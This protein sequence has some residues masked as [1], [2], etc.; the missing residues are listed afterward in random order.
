MAF[1][2]WK[3]GTKRESA[4][5]DSDGGKSFVR[6]IFYSC[7]PNDTDADLLE[8]VFYPQ[9]GAA[10]RDYP[11]YTCESISAP[12][13]QDALAGSP[14]G[15]KIYVLEATYKKSVSSITL[16]IAKSG[17]KPWELGVQ[18]VRFGTETVEIPWVYGYDDSGQY[19]QMLTTAGTPLTQTKTMYLKTIEYDISY[20]YNGKK[21]H[22][23]E[24]H[25]YN[26]N[27]VNICGVDIDSYC[28]KM[29][30]VES[31]IYT[32]YKS[33]GE[34]DYQYETCHYRI[35]V[36]P[37]SW[38]S[39]ILNVSTLA[40]WPKEKG[41]SSSG[42]LYLG[43]IY[44]YTPWKSKSASMNANTPPEFGSIDHVKQAQ[45][46]YWEIK[47]SKTEQIPW[48]EITEPMPLNSNGILDIDAI[49]DPIN[50]PYR[51]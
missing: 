25:S 19:K 7:D 4:Q 31:Q 49:K 29:M 40:L 26:K 42:N 34:I 48:E 5:T 46:E 41:A 10:H 18:N 17:K 2:I 28:G 44:R 20:K 30:P 32:E 47:G 6:E 15:K 33:N 16:G 43:A 11:S 1:S 3:E 27:D 36:H 37:S 39:R 50:H 35:I 45:E 13:Y 38:Y 51:E 8:S 23:T 9:I 21:T 22:T 12:I 24:E 14:A